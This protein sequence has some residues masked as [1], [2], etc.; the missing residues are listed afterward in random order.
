MNKNEYKIINGNKNLIICFGGMALKFG[1]ILPFEFLNYLSSI[2]KNNCDL[3]FFI[4]NHQCWYHKGINDITNN[5]DETIVYLNNIINDGNYQ[6]VI[7]MG[8]SA[9]GY[10]AILF[11][12]MCNNVN[13]VISFI[14]QTIIKNPINLNYSNL[15]NIINKNTKYILYGDKS[16]QDINNA[17][18]ISHC[19]NIECFTNVKIIKSEDC[20]LKSLRDNGFIK[21]TIDDIISEY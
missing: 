15:K 9:G 3:I 10:G 12:S 4:D 8:T 19:E 21:K 18:H 14:P 17:H 7:F 13:H 11:G 1:G 16:V 2:Y 20:N 5:I 6:K